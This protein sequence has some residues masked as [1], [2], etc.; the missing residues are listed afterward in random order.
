MK[1][2]YVSFEVA[3][4]L[5][6]KG[7]DE[8][9]ERV[10]FHYIE[11]D[12]WQRISFNPCCDKFIEDKMLHSPTLQMAMAWLREKHNLHI[13]ICIDDLDWSYQIVNFKNKLDVQYIKDV[14]G[15]N[16]YENAVEAALNHCLT[17]LIQP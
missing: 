15:F 6:E 16:S 10:W 7:F 3:K 11:A 13:I 4:L 2:D 9:T 12:E 14:A 8:K 17:N 1:E 5:K